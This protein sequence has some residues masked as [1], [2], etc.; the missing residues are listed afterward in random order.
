MSKKT[1]TKTTP[2]LQPV[3]AVLF[4]LDGTLLDTARDLAH[5]LNTLLQQEGKAALPYDNIRRVVS[6]GGNAMVA[7]GF[8]TLTGTPEHE[9]LYHRLLNIYGEQ[10]ANYTRPFPGI[11]VLLS[12]LDQFQ[13]PWGVVTNKPSA[14]ALP[15]MEQISLTPPCSAIVCSDQVQQRKPHPEAMFLACEQIGCQ[16]EQTLYVGDHLRDIEAGRNAGMQTIAALY[17]YI[18]EDDN[19][20]DWH[21]DHYIQHPE[22]LTQLIHSLY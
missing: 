7:L 19:P 17:G 21:A 22:E 3:K 10:L 18:E 5:A 9:A 1:G 2:S 14:Y 6:N 12:T 15:L 13:L 20:D 8:G 16:P 4:D 11:E